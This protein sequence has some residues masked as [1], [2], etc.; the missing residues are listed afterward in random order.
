MRTKY[1]F[2]LLLVAVGATLLLA[3]PSYG[4]LAQNNCAQSS[5]KDTFKSMQERQCFLVGTIGNN[6]P[7][8]AFSATEGWNGFEIDLIKAFAKRWLDN[9][10]AITFQT[11]PVETLDDR[12][13]SRRVDLVIGAIWNLD[14]F[15]QTVSFSEPYFQD[16]LIAITQNRDVVEIKDLGQ[17]EL[18]IAVHRPYLTKVQEL[19]TKEGIKVEPIPIDPNGLANALITLKTSDDFDVLISTRSHLEE[20]LDTTQN[21][22]EIVLDSLSYHLIVRQDDEQWLQAIN[23]TL[24]D[25]SKDDEWQRLHDGYF[26]VFNPITI[27]PESNCTEFTLNA[28]PLAPP[29]TDVPTSTNTPTPTLTQV[30]TQTSTLAIIHTIT[31][32]PTFVPTTTV[33]TPT[34][35][36]SATIPISTLSPTPVPIAAMQSESTIGLIQE[37]GYLIAG[38]KADV[39]LFGYKDE[40]GE[41]SGFE[42]DLMR[43]FAKRWFGD[44][45]AIE[46]VQ[47]TSQNRF[48]RLANGDVDI[49]A[50]TMTHRKERDAR[51]D[52]SQTYYLDGQNIL[53]PADDVT[54]LSTDDERIQWLNSK[55]IAAVKGSTSLRRI[56]EFAREKGI[57]ITVVEFEQYDQAIQPLLNGNIDALTTDGGI[58]TGIAQNNTSLQ[59]LLDQGFSN[60][61]YGLG[62]RSGDSYFADLVN[63][64]LQEIKTGKTYDT[65]YKKWFCQTAARTCTPYLLE[66][67]PGAPPY[68]FTTAP[69][70]TTVVL[71]GSSVVDKMMQDGYFVAGVKY[72]APPFGYRNDEGELVGFEVEL[73]REFARRWFGNTAAVEFVQVTSRDRIPKLIGGDIDIIAATMTHAK[74]RDLLIN[75]SQTYYLDGQNILVRK[76]S[77]LRS[78][79]DDERIQALKG[80][81]IAAVKGSTSIRQFAEFTKTYGIDLTIAE[82]EQYDQAVQPLLNGNVDGLTTDRGILI[83][84]AQQYPELVVLLDKNF[85][86]LNAEFRDEPYGLGLPKGDHRFRDLV[87]FTLQEMKED[88]TYDLLYRYWF[89]I[90]FIM[91]DQTVNDEERYD[92][93][94]RYW[95]EDAQNPVDLTQESRK[96]WQPHPVEIWPGINYFS[97]NT[98]SSAAEAT[99]NDLT[100]MIFV[101]TGPSRLGTTSDRI[102]DRSQHPGR[103]KE[104]LIVELDAF[105]ID[106]HEVTNHQYRQCV[107]LGK[108]T[109][110]QEVSILNE[111]EYFYGGKYKNYPVVKVTWEQAQ[112]YCEV[113]GKTLPTEAQW[114][115]AAR[116]TAD[117]TSDPQ[118]LYPWGDSDNGINLRATYADSVYRQDFA[119]PVGIYRYDIPAKI[120]G[121][122]EPIISLNGASSIDVLDMAGNV[123]EWTEDCYVQGFYQ[124]LAGGDQESVRNPNN[125]NTCDASD[126][127]SERT[128]R[129]SGYYDKK[130]T[131]VAVYRQGKPASSYDLMRGFRCAM[132][133]DQTPAN[134]LN[135]AP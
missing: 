83:G 78:G 119:N 13:N 47:V 30:S 122:T 127:Q 116:F 104:Q 29:P 12:L 8:S 75:F 133:G 66:L 14:E 80:K 31:D 73:M 97:G 103:G 71:P 11:I 118:Y 132:P 112:N 86:D 88:G 33:P 128:V 16:D 57:E 114:E 69:L 89:G 59:I 7:F 134:R 37:R 36:L 130:Y 99:Y 52:F 67:L 84:L 48:D 74:D 95:T 18:K 4:A 45:N 19:F 9:D 98:G 77:G 124:T 126:E 23:C 76:D 70:S 81:S 79:S 105:Y 115:K 40:N 1:S 109:P 46:F 25:I 65:L 68:T 131:L 22:H 108:C 20:Y 87:N 110:P 41:W 39:P 34:Q 129:S 101:P 106:Q 53:V 121:F 123:Q 63:Y 44:A 42:I 92:I 54:A 49:L 58:L 27:N 85:K 94:K 24:L 43:E 102:E 55:Q 120:H 17:A 100:P 3:L 5:K 64:T 56:S 10:D 21:L 26:S 15:E 111:A 62:V 61:P 50:A 32:T 125:S 35:T 93:I 51:I 107:D 96:S 90:S 82:F 28:T 91:Q 113:F 6:A 38:V 60:E 117:T 2:Y 72:D 135:S